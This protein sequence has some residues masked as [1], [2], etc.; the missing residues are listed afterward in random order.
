MLSIGPPR[1]MTSAFRV[2]ALVAQNIAREASIATLAPDGRAPRA[3]S[4]PGLHC[5]CYT[6]QRV[7][8]LVSPVMLRRPHAGYRHLRGDANAL[9][10]DPT[11]VMRGTLHLPATSIRRPLVR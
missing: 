6:R 11:T 2:P 5:S 9:R 7:D 10:I 3:R 1:Q 8:D 4:C